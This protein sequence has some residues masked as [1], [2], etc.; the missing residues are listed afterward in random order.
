MKPSAITYLSSILYRLTFSFSLGLSHIEGKQAYNIHLCIISAG[1]FASLAVGSKI[2]PIAVAKRRIKAGKRQRGG[3]KSGL[4][5]TRNSWGFALCRPTRARIY[6]RVLVDSAPRT[7]RV[8]DKSGRTRVYDKYCM[9][10]AACS[11]RELPRRPR[12]PETRSTIEFMPQT[13][14]PNSQQSLA[15]RR[16]RQNTE[17]ERNYTRGAHTK[18][19]YN[20]NNTGCSIALFICY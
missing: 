19:V 1:T 13:N 3:K 20:N 15:C 17:Q 7:G 16:R 4:P 2:I 8:R 11:G 9:A 14:G 10:M 5:E 6:R 18:A 12:T